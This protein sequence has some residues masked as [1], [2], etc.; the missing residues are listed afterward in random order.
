VDVCR[1]HRFGLFDNEV[2]LYGLDE[3]TETVRLLNVA[4]PAGRRPCR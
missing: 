4:N 3:L 2:R 1:T